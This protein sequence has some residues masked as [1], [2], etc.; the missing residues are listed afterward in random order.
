MLQNQF[1]ASLHAVSRHEDFL[2]QLDA[3]HLESVYVWEGIESNCQTRLL[4]Q[5]SWRTCLRIHMSGPYSSPLSQCPLLW[6][7]QNDSDFLDSVILSSLRIT[8]LND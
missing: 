5:T 7:S 3:K 6:S 8:V 2:L 4:I 1:P